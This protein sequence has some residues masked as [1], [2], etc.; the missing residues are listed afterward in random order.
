MLLVLGGEHFLQCSGIGFHESLRLALQS[1]VGVLV[2]PGQAMPGFF[3]VLDRVCP[4][5]VDVSKVYV[6]RRNWFAEFGPVDAAGAA[7]HI[8]D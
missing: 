3:P 8:S 6:M 4:N 1:E 7:A 5:T 2:E